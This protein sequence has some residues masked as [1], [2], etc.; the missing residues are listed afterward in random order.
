M[1]SE[2]DPQ[3]SAPHPQ[4]DSNSTQGPNG[5]E[6]KHKQPS[7]LDALLPIIALVVMLTGAVYLFSSDSSSGANQIALIMAACVA[8]IV[9]VK[10]G[11]TWKE[12]EE[13]IVF[14]VSMATG[15]LLILFTVGSL[16]GTWILSGTVPTMIYYGM[17]IL[18]PEYF[19]AAS[20]LLC[21]VVA[22]SIGSSWTVAGTLGIALIGVAG[23]M[24][25]NVEITAGAIISGAYFGDK[26]SPMSDTTNLAPAVAGT[27]LFSH[28]RHMAWTT[29]PSII[30]ALIGFLLLGFNTEIPATGAELAK[31]MAVLQTQFSPGVHL[32][33][34]LLVVLVLAYKKMPAFP[35]VIVG[36]LAGAVCAAL[37]QFDNVI[38]FVGD[39]S[40]LPSVAL[41]KGIWIAMFDGYTAN[42]GNAMIDSLLSRG[43]MGSMINTVWLILCAMAFGGVMERTGL[44]QRILQSMLVF[45]KSSSSLILTTLVSCIGA[46]LITADQFIAII[47]PGRMLKVEYNKYGLAPVNLSRALEDSATI[48]SPLVPWNTCGAY[49]ASTLGVATI[50]YLPYAFFN[51]VC[52]LI[53][54]SYAYFDFKILKLED[55]D[56]AELATS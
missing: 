10:N 26:M 5:P 39:P 4:Q 1:T 27:D 44:L 30:I 6:T 28:I 36:T 34:P 47:L 45:V 37:F 52:P 2:T 29:T 21:A 56:D 46:N 24:G 54:A 11:Y 13:G 43:G 49:M 53:S 3:Q 38:K 9:G 35:T 50:A 7:L 25:L 51:L 55:M 19:Y 23:A 18:N 12:M 14:S 32:L 8:L 48:T 41:I 17:K 20:C 42:T 22:I 15:A 16:I 40:L 31:T 33:I